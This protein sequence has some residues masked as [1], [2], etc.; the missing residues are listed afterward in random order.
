MPSQTISAGY[1]VCFAEL[2]QN[3][4]TKHMGSMTGCKACV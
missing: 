4:D 2:Y 1:T 3:V